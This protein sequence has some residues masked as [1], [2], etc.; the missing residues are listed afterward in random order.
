MIVEQLNPPRCYP[1]PTTDIVGGDDLFVQPHFIA[2]I[3][4]KREGA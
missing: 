4:E 3:V 2:V 1:R